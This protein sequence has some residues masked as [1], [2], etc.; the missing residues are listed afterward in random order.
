MR[1]VLAAPRGRREPG[2]WVGAPLAR[3]ARTAACS[4]GAAA[5]WTTCRVPGMLHAAMLRSPHAHARIVR[6]DTRDAAATPGVLGVLTGADAA[7]ARADP[8]PDPHA[9]AP[10]ATTA[11]P[12]IASGSS[13]SPSPPWRPSTG[14]RPRTPL[15]RIVA[16]YEPLDAVVDPEAAIRPDAPLLYPELGTNVLWHDVLVLRRR[17]RRLRRR[18]RHRARALRDP[19]LRLDAAGDL[20]R[21][22]RARPGHRRLHVLD[23]RS[24]PGAHARHPGRVA[25]GA[26][27][28]PAAD[29][30]RH[31][32]GLRQ[33]APA[34]PTCWS[35]RCW[36]ARPAAR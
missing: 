5:M 9:G 25:R 36:R 12:S 27:G 17:R 2:P 24:A 14:R 13:A 29:R 30:A 3:H 11:W 21:H 26:P 18:R 19:A 33:Q 15:E 8:S 34:R 22:R 28:A 7:G 32:R 1:A 10:R 23:E 35:A 6:V 4:P 31:R 16:E 20:R